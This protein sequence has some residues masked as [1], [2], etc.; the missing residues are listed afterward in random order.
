M[1]LNSSK[2][3]NQNSGALAASKVASVNNAM[4]LGFS[5]YNSKASTQY[6]QLYDAASVPADAV[7]PLMTWVVPAN[8]TLSV[9]YEGVGRPCLTGIVLCNSSTAATK[10]LGSADCIFDIQVGAFV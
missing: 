5:V 1:A 10:T 2:I 7:V 6:I 3:T 4:L 8:S 9:Q